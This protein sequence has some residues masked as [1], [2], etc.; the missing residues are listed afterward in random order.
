MFF[1]LTA[2]LPPLP[3]PSLPADSW[4]DFTLPLDVLPVRADRALPL[5]VKSFSREKL[6]LLFRQG[7]VRLRGRAI[8]GRTSVRGGDVLSV[9]LGALPPPLVVP[10]PRSV[11]VV[12]EDEAL[13]LVNKPFGLLTHPHLGF[14]GE[15][16]YQGVLAHTNVVG[17]HDASRYGVVQRLDRE[18]TGLVVFTKSQRAYRALAAAFSRREVDKQYFA[19]VRGVPVLR[20]GSI[21][22]PLGKDVRHRVRQAVCHSGKYARTDWELLEAYR[23][24]AS[25]LCC[26][27]KTGRTHQI[28]LHLAHRGHPLLG[29]TLYGYVSDGVSLLSGGFFLHAGLLAF[30]HPLSGEFMSWEV[31]L[32]V[33]FVRQRDFL[34][35]LEGSCGDA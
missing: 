15:T 16:L 14:Q 11:E 35:Q 23:A 32:P 19:L 26:V 24:V 8:S 28:R 6:K 12:Y 4:R 33:A 21:E 30:K 25:C 18:T 3:P 31:P 22:L 5:L 9:C 7:A 29:D 27:P 2:D 10:A 13:I 17:G 20:S 1:V 34:R